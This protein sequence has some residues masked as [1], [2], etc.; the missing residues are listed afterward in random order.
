MNEFD[1]V[2]VG[3]GTAGAIIA[4]RLAEGGAGTVCLL[5]AGPP[6]EGD[7]ALLE[8]RNWPVLLHSHYDADYAIEPQ[9]RGNSD[10]RHSRAVVL[11]GCS[12]HNSAIAF[13]AWDAD[14][15]YWEEHGAVGWGPAA[16]RPLYERVL[17][18]LHIEPAPPVNACAAAFVEAAQQAGHHL[19]DFTAAV[20]REG[21]GWVQLHRSGKHRTSSSTAYLHPLDRLPAGLDVRTET[22]V[23]RVLLD[24]GVAVG[25]ETETGVVR[26]RAETIVCCGAFDSPKLLLLSGIGPGQHLQD[27]GVAVN[28]DIP[29]VG[30][31]LSDHPEGVV[32]FES[33]LPVPDE[34][35]QFLEAVLIARASPA[36]TGPELMVWFFT[37]PFDEVTLRAGD[38]R[39]G[40]R[41]CIAPDVL[42]PRSEGFVRLRSPHPAEPPVIDPRYFSDSECYDEQTM[43]AGIRIARQIAKQP[44]LRRWTEREASPGGDVD[45]DEALSEYVRRTHY[46]AFHPVGTCRMGP[47][48]ARSSVVDADLRVHGVRRLR[49][50]DASVFP[51]MIGVNPVITTMMVGERCAELIKSTPMP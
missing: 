35:T 19:V 28:V 1:Y 10:I 15:A 11:G 24:G 8:L 26:A 39:R 4:A 21:V 29:A 32:A 14:H 25:V 2:V 17:D 46:T 36:A 18:R 33:S 49:V 6:D 22:R 38:D 27:V 45:V 47:S 41:F 44:A 48:A 23:H 31:H 20:P 42:Y 9:Q 43:L 5:E 3:G 12:S 30:E 7:A 13:R 37:A 40:R 34:S 50:A 16:C 51:R